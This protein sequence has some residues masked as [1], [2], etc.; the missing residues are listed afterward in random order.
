VRDGEIDNG[1]GVE[2]IALGVAILGAVLLAQ[3]GAN[4]SAPVAHVAPWP[5]S[6]CLAMLGRK[7]GLAA[8][9]L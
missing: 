4:L 7:L 5:V 8:Y 2:Q 3:M 9:A 6:P 1:C